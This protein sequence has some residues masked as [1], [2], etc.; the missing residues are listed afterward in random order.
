MATR[1]PQAQTRSQYTPYWGVY[2]TAGDLPNVAGAAVQDSDLEV[3][4]DAYVI[5]AGLRYVCTTATLGAAQ[6]SAMGL[7]NANFDAFGRLRVSNPQ[8]IFDSKLVYDEQPLYWSENLTGGSTSF[9]DQPNAQMILSTGGGAGQAIR[10]TRRF[11]NYQPGKSQLIFQTFNANGVESG[12]IKRIGY[13]DS[14]DGI[15]FELDGTTILGSGLSFVRRSSGANPTDSVPQASWNLDTLDGSGGPSNP[16]GLNVKSNAVQ[17][18]VIDFEWL[19]VGSARVGF[20][21]DGQI[22]YAHRFDCANI[23]Q[24]VYMQSPNLPLRYELDAPSVA[25]SGTLD[26]ICGTVISEGGQGATGTPFG[27]D[28]PRSANVANNASTTLLSIRHRAGFE[29]ITIIPTNVAPLTAGN[30][31]STWELLYNPTFPTPPAWGLATVRGFCELDAPSVGV[32]DGQATP[33]S[34]T[35][36][37]SGVFSNGAPAVPLDLRSTTLT[38]GADVLPVVPVS[39]V[40]SLVVTNRSGGNEQYLAAI[41]WIAL[42]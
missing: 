20:V 38:L 5:E 37:A 32:A 24:S 35:V 21:I 26:C 6:W 17:I 14:T 12:I 39:D 34:G 40:I 3:G 31:A 10:Q 16:S 13:F 9:Y 15:F 23:Q 30:G 4:D 41:N 33:G 36:I 7:V 27:F 2:A 28:S 22:V 29:R 1:T 8:T 25:S 18:L 11:F 42:T 19:G